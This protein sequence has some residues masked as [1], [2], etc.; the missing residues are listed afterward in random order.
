MRRTNS[1]QQNKYK[2][3]SVILIFLLII[4]V[5]LIYL[6]DQ[7]ISKIQERLL[8]YPLMKLESK[9]FY[10]D[11]S[12]AIM[13]LGDK[14]CV[15]LRRL[16]KLKDLNCNETCLAISTESQYGNCFVSFLS[17][18]AIARGSGMKRIV[19]K[20]NFLF[21]SR[22]FT[23]EGISVEKSPNHDQCYYYNFFYY[24][25]EM[26]PLIWKF[27]PRIRPELYEV[28]VEN[29]PKKDI[30]ENG[31]VVHIRSGDCFRVKPH[32]KYGQPPCNYY[33]DVIRSR[34]WS[35]IILIAQDT[36]NPCVNIIA[37][38]ADEFHQL[39]LIDDL[40]YMLSAKNFVTSVSTLTNAAV[41]ISKNIENLYTFNH[42]RF[43]DINTMNCVPTK[44]FRRKVLKY[45]ED[46]PEQRKI[47]VNEKS[48]EKWEH[49]P[50]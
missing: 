19:I 5:F 16:L 17:A 3:T 12:D 1:K 6:F 23:Y 18:L 2:Y 50:K 40:G 31:L 49:F 21:I 35:K 36:K 30:P 22:N 39:N 46:S 7:Y 33:M 34:N 15:R 41:T 24:P 38:V 43:Y 11:Y 44:Y 42:T 25:N 45:W 9:Y 48:C 28:L 13:R 26:K 4:Y 27:M 47:M 37:K 14:P 32:W 29:V 20:N 8:F 10:D